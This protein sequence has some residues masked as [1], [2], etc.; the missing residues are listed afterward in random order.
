MV[1]LL[2]GGFA[3]TV[4]IFFLTLLGS[5]PL[6][7]PVALGRISRFGPVRWLMRIYISIM[8]GTPLILQ[9]MVVFFGPYY[10]LH[11][12][13]GPGFRFWAVIIAFIINYA[14][15]F[16]EIY[17]SGIAAV[18]AG[19]REAAQVLGYSKSQTFARIV[20]PQVVKIVL[21]SVTNE[22]ITLVKDTSLATIIAVTEMFTLAKKI[23]SSQ[24]TLMPFVIAAVFYYVFN[25]AVAFCM[26]RCEKALAYY[27]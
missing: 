24:A 5:L 13:V 22:V 15:Y 14:A 26:E 3:Q 11:I 16:G 6:G 17:R 8:R 23:A 7:I 10:L 4:A 19:Q 18:P 12:N 21:P 27:R 20:L 9:L 1:S 2:A 25:A